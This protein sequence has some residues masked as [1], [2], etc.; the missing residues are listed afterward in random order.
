MITDLEKLTPAEHELLLKA[1]VLMSVLASCA[2]GEVNKHQKA[3]AIRLSHIKTFT[4]VPVLRPY[5]REVERNFREDFES[6]AKTYYPFD[7]KKRKDLKKEIEKVQHLFRKLDPEY[8][9][10]L[11]RSLERYANHVK[12]A[13]HSIFHDF[14]FPIVILELKHH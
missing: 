11:S 12:R 9:D 8:A 5:Y 13:S 6:V 1:P 10:L 14:V 7:D 3:D 4:A 2:G